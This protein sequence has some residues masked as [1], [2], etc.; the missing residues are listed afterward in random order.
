VQLKARLPAPLEAY[1]QRGMARPA[2]A[3]AVSRE[4]AAAE[5]V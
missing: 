1:R 5:S 4:R 3:R 2:L